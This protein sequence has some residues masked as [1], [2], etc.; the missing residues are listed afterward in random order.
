MENQLGAQ[1]VMVDDIGRIVVAQGGQYNTPEGIMAGYNPVKMT[2]ET[3]TKRQKRIS[4]TLADKYDLTPKQI[5]D[6]ISG[7]LTADDAMFQD[8][9]FN[10][11]GTDIQT[12][13]LTNLRNI[14]IARQNFAD[15]TKTTD[16]I[17]DLKTDTKQNN[18]NTDNNDGGGHIKPP[19]SY[20]TDTSTGGSEDHRTQGGG[21]WSNADWGPDTGEFNQGGRVYLN[22]G[23]LAGL[24]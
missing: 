10:L 19:G 2:D 7:E 8:K 17:V 6:L 18:K 23:G 13:L 1:G 20:D 22:L 5:S 16:N 12:N 4:K 3:F 15:I 24:L 9:K 14:E 21:G 11:R